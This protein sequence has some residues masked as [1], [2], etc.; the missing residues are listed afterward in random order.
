MVLPIFT[1]VE[2]KLVVGIADFAVSND[3]SVILTTYS[4]GSCLG[5][6]IYDPV[7]KVAGL[8]HIM[9][10]DSGIDRAKAERTPAM[11]LDTGLPLL[12]NAAA[13]LRAEASRLQICVAGGAQIMDSVGFFNIGKRNHQMLMDLL[14]RGSLRLTVEEVGGMVN[15][16]MHVHVSNGDVMLK[17]SGNP[18][19]CYLCK[20]STT[21]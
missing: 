18:K 10:P 17:T 5:I 12:L 21:T 7:V 1:G 19:E 11:F 2:H 20:N 3:P 13:E 9:L 14:N 16:T 15:R 6:S 8:L 4:L